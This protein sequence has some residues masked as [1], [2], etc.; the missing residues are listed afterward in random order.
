M[1]VAHAPPDSPSKF[2]PDID[3]CGMGVGGRSMRCDAPRAVDADPRIDVAILKVPGPISSALQIGAR[4]AVFVRLDK[5]PLHA[6]RGTRRRLACAKP[7]V[8]TIDDIGA[9]SS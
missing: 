3:V 8:F 2:A 7:E 5:A 9:G 1:Q 4:L 6:A